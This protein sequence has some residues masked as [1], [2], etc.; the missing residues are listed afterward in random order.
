MQTAHSP[1]PSVGADAGASASLSLDTG[2]EVFA[3]FARG[4]LYETYPF[5]PFPSLPYLVLG[6][7]Y[8]VVLLD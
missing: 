7:K 1:T 8:K 3:F 4:C 5:L 2:T 6:E